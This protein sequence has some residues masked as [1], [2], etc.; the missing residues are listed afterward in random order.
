LCITRFIPPSGIW[1]YRVEVAFLFS[2]GNSLCVRHHTHIRRASG[3]RV[4]FC[5]F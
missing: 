4:E 5:L 1:F 3:L 2:F